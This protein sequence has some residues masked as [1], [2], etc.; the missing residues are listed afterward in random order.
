MKTC[1]EAAEVLREKVSRMRL[2]KT[3]KISQRLNIIG[4][5]NLTNNYIKK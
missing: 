4:Q 5:V 2:V 3:M 1:H